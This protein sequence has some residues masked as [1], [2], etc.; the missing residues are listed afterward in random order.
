MP[1]GSTTAPR[2]VD[3]RRIETI[4]KKFAAVVMLLN[5]V[6][7]RATCSSDVASKPPSDMTDE[8]TWVNVAATADVD[9]ISYRT[10]KMAVV[11]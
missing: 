7:R 11:M 2:A 4:G 10:G 8:Q 9:V 1:L 3:A 6:V 5:I